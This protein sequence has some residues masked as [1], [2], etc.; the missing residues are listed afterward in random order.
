MLFLLFI[1]ATQVSQTYLYREIFNKKTPLPI[2]NSNKVYVQTKSFFCPS[3]DIQQNLL[4]DKI[5]FSERFMNLSSIGSST[6][7]NYYVF[8]KNA[9]IA[10]NNSEW[11]AVSDKIFC[12]IKNQAIL[13]KITKIWYL[14]LRKVWPLSPKIDFWRKNWILV[15]VST[16][17]RD[18]VLLR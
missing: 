13:E 16:Q 4:E 11:P 1:L 17:F 9:N 15:F 8:I 3:N 6:G 5:Y 10:P 14:V 7:L 18:F 12:Q 2:H